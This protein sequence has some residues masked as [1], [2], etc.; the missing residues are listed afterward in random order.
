MD[1]TCTLYG[2]FLTKTIKKNP[3]NKTIL[4]L[5]ENKSWRELTH[6]I[7]LAVTH[8][9][10]RETMTYFSYSNNSNLYLKTLKIEQIGMRKV[11]GKKWFQE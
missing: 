6:V 9:I 3:I 2:S 11:K 4:V 8:V 10:C 5:V 1:P 7:I